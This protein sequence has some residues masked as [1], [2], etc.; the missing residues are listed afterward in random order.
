MS[1]PRGIRRIVAQG[2]SVATTRIALIGASLVSS[3]IVAR[4]LPITERGLLGLLMAVAA[5]A[6]QF[7]NLG[8]PVAN[9]YLVARHPEETEKVVGNTTRSFVGVA[10]LLAVFC[11]AA[12]RY[13]HAWASLSGLS[14]LMVWPIAVSGLALMHIQNILSG[15]FRFS[16]SNVV[17]LIA[18]LGVIGGMLGLWLAGCTTAVWFAGATTAFSLLGACWGLRKGG[19][20]PVLRVWSGRL[21]SEQVSLGGKAYIACI[22]SFV[23]SRLP[24]YLVEARGGLK[25]LAFYTQALSIADTMLVVPI[26]FGTVL[27]PNM[28]ST[29][30]APERIRST[31]KLAAITACLMLL[32]TG[33]AALAGPVLLPFIYGKAY[34][35]SMPMLFAML[36]GVAALGVCSVMQNALSA[37]GY[38]WAAVAS[39]I[40]GVASVSLSLVATSTVMGCAWAY[41]IGAMVMLACSS[42][43]WWIHRNDW[44][45]VVDMRT[46]QSPDPL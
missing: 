21:W 28:A 23:L 39:P 7:G 19:F 33:L 43:G 40:V 30:E 32:A 13:V 17:E 34:A 46:S 16:A 2:A 24:L 8:L 5:L 37:N 20:R 12:T 26:A 11:P 27:F 38:P 3:I 36:P 1:H 6:I 35:A 25:G 14:G 4:A 9:A 29:R 42:L 41:S 44:E 15:Q 45:E 10:V 22:A 31:L 18:R